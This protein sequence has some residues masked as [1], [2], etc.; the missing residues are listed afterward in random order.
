MDE[1]LYGVDLSEDV[2]PVM[3]RNAMVKCFMQAHCE[4]MAEMKEYHKFGSEE[5]FTKMEQ[6]NVI[7]IIKS[8]FAE[9]GADFDQPTKED[10]LKAIDKLTEYAANFR[11]PE[12][13]KKHYDEMVLI[14]SKVK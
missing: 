5:E 10:L 13:I 7:A 4:V 1:K 9:L 11:S 12:I 6:M 8:I 14:L 2:T 3:A